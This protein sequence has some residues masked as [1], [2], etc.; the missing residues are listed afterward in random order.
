MTLAVLP[1]ETDPARAD[2]HPSAPRH[3]RREPGRRSARD[4]AVVEIYGDGTF[5][6]PRLVTADGPIAAA[7]TVQGAEPGD[8]GVPGL[9]PA[10]EAHLGRLHASGG[11]LREAVRALTHG[12]R[13]GAP[14][15][16]RESCLGQLA[17]IE[18][19][20]GSLRR[21]AT[22]AGLVL[23]QDPAPDSEGAVHALVA[24]AW[25]HLEHGEL[26]ETRR[27]LDDVA[28]RC[29]PD[30]EPWLAT[31]RLLVEARLLVALRLPDAATRLLAEAL[32]LETP[33]STSGW[34]ADLL[35]TER[36]DSLL[37]AGEPHRALA[38]LT[39]LPQRTLVEAAVVAATAR[40]DIGDVR[41]AHAVLG[42]VV[43]DLDCSPLSLQVRAQLLEALL[44]KGRGKHERAHLLVDRALRSAGAEEMRTPI[45]RESR[46]LRAFV[47]Q[48]A[49]LMR[50]HR[51]L[52]SVLEP[53]PVVGPARPSG[54]EAP[55]HLVGTTLT[56]R[57]S[58]VLDLLAQMYSTEEIANA[59]FVSA[60]TVKTHL[61]GIFG[62]LCVSRRVD[63][64]R[65]GRQ[66]GLC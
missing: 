27:L 30:L 28:D 22:H 36:A 54:Q 64:V 2:D 45:T 32:E 38:A 13:A 31:N 66:L 6:P 39:P 24:T 18:A 57:E 9:A 43:S 33:L 42:P 20:Q 34:I 60:N 37:A 17:L 29:D 46:W 48:D 41:G 1:A 49:A 7:T 4:W 53:D 52:L 14:S 65:R 21:A 3:S 23:D 35:T 61:K 47:D 19:F 11:R 40:R 12:A 15:A 51:S 62:K 58:Q 50:S 55:E 63:A 5:G 56:E 25:I 16:A 59:L 26:D 8:A 10:L 44:A